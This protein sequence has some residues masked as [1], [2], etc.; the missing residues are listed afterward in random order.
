MANSLRL[1]GNRRAA[2]RFAVTGLSTAVLCG[3][4]LTHSVAESKGIEARSKKLV[5][6][7]KHAKT[8]VQIIWQGGGS[9]HGG[10]SFHASF[11]APMVPAAEIG[12]ES[13]ST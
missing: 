10:S 7:E 8:E 13:V 11:P 9:I 1:S 12:V 2:V 6:F 3:G 5:A 4:L